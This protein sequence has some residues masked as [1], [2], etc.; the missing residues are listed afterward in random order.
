MKILHTADWHL[1]KRL[2]QVSRLPEQAEVLQEICFIADQEAVDVV[3]V[4]GDLFDTFNPSS[5][6]MELL[7]STLHQLAKGG[8]RLVIA[9]AGNH[10]SPERIDAPDALA[11]VSGIVF[12]GHP[13][14][15]LRLLELPTGLRITQSAPGFLEVWLPNSSFPLR[16]VHT[17][18]ANEA[19]LRQAIG[20]SGQGDDALRDYLELH[21]QT[22]AEN[23]L[24]DAG[25]NLLVTHL[26]FQREGEPTEEEPADEKPILHVGGAQA[27]F[28]RNIPAGYHYVA[29]G[30]LHRPHTVD[31]SPCEIRYAGSPL[32]YSF[33][34]AN[35]QKS[36]EILTVEPDRVAERRSI[37]LTS[38]K[39]LL[40]HRFETMEEGIAWLQAHP[41]AWVELTWVT[42]TYL[43]SA[44]K[45][46]LFAVHSGIIQI[47][48]E[49]R[50][51]SNAAPET[52]SLDL[53][54]DISELFTQ[55]FESKHQMPPNDSLRQLF[56]EILSQS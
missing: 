40:R 22:I 34:E 38:G 35:Q 20:L 29:L 25:C 45:E 30:H 8:Q 2:D 43:E 55:Y 10:D 48:P 3:V 47:I 44:D 54:Q 42:D 12:V 37:P 17:P 50:R 16:I 32:C 36:V 46:N 53:S 11:R 19:R 33:A 24:D 39:P 27:I 41:N 31:K 21:W 51:S 52:P 4:A 49:I 56:K 13:A 1:G 23:H 26:F 7:Y 18:Y 9:I 14:E 28:S 6:A 5:D 15:T